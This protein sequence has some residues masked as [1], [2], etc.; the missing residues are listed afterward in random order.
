MTVVSRRTL[1]FVFFASLAASFV[2]RA[3]VKTT[4]ACRPIAD[5]RQR[6]ACYDAAVDAAS[7]SRSGVPVNAEAPPM[8]G[9]P[10]GVSTSPSAALPPPSTAPPSPPHVV[11]KAT[12]EPPPPDTLNALVTAVVANP[13]GRLTIDLDNGERWAQ[14]DTSPFVLHVGDRVNVKHMRL[15]SYVL[16]VVGSGRG[17]RV[18]LEASSA[19]N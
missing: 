8:S 7:A 14:A 5:D 16:E 17:M 11:K 3:A 18:K 6:L 10:A 19:T 13:L 12:P 9:P 4:E 1:A 2:A 15:G